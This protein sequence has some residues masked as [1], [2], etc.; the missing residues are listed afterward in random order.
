MGMVYVLRRATDEQ[1]SFLRRRPELLERFLF[2]EPREAAVKATGLMDKLVSAFGF[3]APAETLGEPREEGD[4]IDLDKS[5]HL[6]HFLLAGSADGTEAPESTLLQDWP[7]I[8]DVEVGWGRAWAIDSE[9]IRRF[10]TALTQVR[11]DEL[12]ARFD[13]AE[14]TR[15]DVYLGD[16]FEGDERSGCEYVLEYLLILRTFVSETAR[17]GCGAIGYLT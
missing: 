14:M 3:K 15:Q 9:G 11:E 1:L 16:T 4:E 8:G 17:R 2:D 10:D 6:L 12:F 5:W 13:T 7:Q